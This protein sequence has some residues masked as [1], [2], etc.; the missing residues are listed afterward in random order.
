MKPERS[1]ILLSA[2]IDRKPSRHAAW[3]LLILA[4]SVAG[5]LAGFAFGKWISIPRIPRCQFAPDVII[6]SGDYDS[7]TGYWSEYDCVFRGRV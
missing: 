1:Y 4:L 3:F 6:G 5:Y 2:G 7:E